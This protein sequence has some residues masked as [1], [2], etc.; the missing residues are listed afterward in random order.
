MPVELV[1]IDLIDDNPFQPRSSYSTKKIDE[2]AYSIKENGLRQTPEGRRVDGRY[3]LVYGHYRKRAFKKLAKDD[4]EKF[5]KMPLDIKEVSDQD[6]SIYALEENLRR[7]DITPIDVARSV[8]M[9]LTNFTEESETSLAKR[10][11][12]SQ[13]NISN[14]RRVLKCPPEILEK[15]DQGVINF[16]MARELL[17]F[18]GINAGTYEEWDSKA[19]HQA[20]YPKDE[21]Y[22]MKSALKGLKTG[23]NNYGHPC[24]VEGIK[25]SIDAVAVSN[26][27]HLEKGGSYDTS[28][29]PLFDTR[30]AG[31]LK[32]PKMIRTYRTQTEARHFCTD[33]RCWDGEQK[34]HKDEQAAAAQEQMK[35]DIAKRIAAFQPVP[36][37]QEGGISQEITR[38]H[39]P[40]GIFAEVEASYSADTIAQTTSKVKMP[41]KYWG[42]LYISTGDAIPG[43]G[44]EC[45]QLVP[46]EEYQG[47]IRTYHVPK[48]REYEEYYEE[49]RKDPSGFYDGMLVKHG[50]NDCVLVG[51][52]VTFLPQKGDIAQETPAE[53]TE[54]YL[55]DMNEEETEEVTK[56][57]PRFESL[58]E[59]CKGCLNRGTCDRTHSLSVSD[60][61]NEKDL[62]VCPQRVTKDGL[63][64][65]QKQA[66]VEMPESVKVLTTEKAGTRAEVLDLR[67]LRLDRYSGELKAGF[68]Q[69]NG[70]YQVPL[71]SMEDP[72][73]CTERCIA[74]FH[75]AFDSSDKEPKVYQVC[76][77]PKCVAKKKAAFTRAKNAAGAARKKAELSAIKEAVGKTTTLDKPRIELVLLSHLLG[78][79]A[80]GNRYGK[81]GAEAYLAGLLGVKRPQGWD[82]D[83]DKNRTKAFLEAM[84]KLSEEELSRVTVEFC[85]TM[86]TYEGDVAH[87]KC[88]ATEI[89]DELHVGI[90]VEKEED[91]KLSGGK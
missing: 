25:R 40:P 59:V 26:L 91:K 90:Q 70:G 81:D 19:G 5:G 9:Y 37:P 35:Q 54:D 73:E 64:E 21:T 7:D 13:G 1:P 58:E 3:Q 77:E 50:K 30:D 51:P 52:P 39:V 86:L 66:T 67:D 2:L 75:F 72:D 71:E 85:L 27:R 43:P 74:G 53:P 47:E 57:M 68:V 32:C 29:E 10:L 49:R 36:H 60:E 55:E 42:K 45:Y 33:F 88:Q 41:F 89:L 8:E 83:W 22:L 63:A 17:I 12:Q 15:I 28:K 79:H 14:M 34:V 87:Y 46:R 38:E 6:M 18:Q 11:N 31:C 16:T 84:D 61:A 4:P 80:Q 76:T 62:F 20:K 65:L 23:N 82:A 69:L 56:D 48:G 78:R 44:K 24:T